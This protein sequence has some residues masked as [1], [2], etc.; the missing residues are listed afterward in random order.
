MAGD[1]PEIA[2]LVRADARMIASAKLAP[3][4]PKKRPRSCAL[5]ALP[6]RAPAHRTP[7]CGRVEGEWA[8][9]V[10]ACTDCG[11]RRPPNPESKCDDFIS[12]RSP[13]CHAV[14]A[15]VPPRRIARPFHASPPLPPPGSHARWGSAARGGANSHRPSKFGPSKSALP[16]LD[17]RVLKRYLMP[18]YYSHPPPVCLY[19]CM[20]R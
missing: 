4:K 15:P 5:L 19:A 9:T 7:Q 12:L 10:T 20:R 3:T 16:L 2:A 17:C 11:A 18:L 13:R 14:D 6:S 1:A 8:A